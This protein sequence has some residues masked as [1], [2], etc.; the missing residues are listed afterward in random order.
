[1]KIRNSLLACAVIASAGQAKLDDAARLSIL[2]PTDKTLWLVPDQ[3]AVG[4]VLVTDPSGWDQKSGTFFAIDSRYLEGK[5]AT[6][7][8]PVTSETLT[9]N[10]KVD[11]AAVLPFLKVLGGS[12]KKAKQVSITATDEHITQAS[13][14]DAL[15]ELLLT[16]DRR[17]QSADERARSALFARIN[18]A[19]AQTGNRSET[20][21]Y[22][23]VTK[24]YRTTTTSWNDGR[25]TSAAIGVGCGEPPTA[26]DML[27]ATASTNGSANAAAAPTAPVASM[28]ANGSGIAGSFSVAATAN[29]AAK[30]SGSVAV[31][32]NG[33]VT[34]SLQ[35]P[36][37]G[38]AASGA[39]GSTQA[40]NGAA[41]T[42]A[43]AAKPTV[44]VSAPGCTLGKFSI[45]GGASSNGSNKG[46]ILFIQM[47]P[48]FRNSLGRLYIPLPGGDDQVLAPAT[49]RRS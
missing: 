22:W 19:A 7:E 17:T 46:G 30:P 4:T 12:F 37:S 15:R 33:S 10:K 9:V 45:G 5:L 34:G 6:N 1:M 11:I 35:L 8:G 28:A 18:A 39:S 21:R 42:G 31:G 2:S 48:I 24:V 47:K 32:A 26:P 25:S 23:I 38:G 36:P 27:T 41:A 3:V 40:P 29:D 20:A 49:V 14:M 44:P 13:D 43:V 16:Y